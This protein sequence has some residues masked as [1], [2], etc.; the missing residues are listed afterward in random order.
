ML[1]AKS[2][3]PDEDAVVRAMRDFH[4]DAMGRVLR[5]PATA[6]LAPIAPSEAPVSAGGSDSPPRE[7]EGVAGQPAAVPLPQSRSAT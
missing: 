3:G 2:S 7:R 5:G 4:F 6:D 1:F